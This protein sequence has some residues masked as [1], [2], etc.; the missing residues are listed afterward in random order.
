[1]FDVCKSKNK[2]SD[3]KEETNVSTNLCKDDE[4]GVLPDLMVARPGRTCFF[5]VLEEGLSLPLDEFSVRLL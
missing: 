3:E 2:G 5:S 4:F 1:M